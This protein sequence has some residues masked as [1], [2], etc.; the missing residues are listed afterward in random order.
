ME[1]KLATNREVQDRSPT[2]P[3]ESRHERSLGET[4]PERLFFTPFEV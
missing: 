3:I 4:S 2:L 1:E